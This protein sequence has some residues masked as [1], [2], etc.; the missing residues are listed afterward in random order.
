MIMASEKALFSP[1]FFYLKFLELFKLFQSIFS[2]RV[3]IAL[4]GLHQENGDFS[5]I[6]C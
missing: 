2:P 1:L 6:I 4:L 3:R 5:L